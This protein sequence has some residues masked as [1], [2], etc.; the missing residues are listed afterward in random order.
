MKPLIWKSWTYSKFKK[1]GHF[2]S[3]ISVFQWSAKQ[4]VYRA[5][6]NISPWNSLAFPC[7]TAAQI[8]R[9]PAWFS[10]L[11]Y[12]HMIT[13]ASKCWCTF[14]K[15]ETPAKCNTP[16]LKDQISIIIPFLCKCSPYILYPYMDISPFLKDLWIW[17]YLR[18]ANYCWS[19]TS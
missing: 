4:W 3:M 19:W 6:T 13:I 15:G 10:T 12:L 8:Y 5:Y 14:K 9:K 1:V 11:I 16:F 17:D 18:R 2:L 7:I